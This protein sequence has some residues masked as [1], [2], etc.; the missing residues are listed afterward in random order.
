[1]LKRD[2]RIRVSRRNYDGSSDGAQRK[3]RLRVRSIFGGMCNMRVLFKDFGCA[4]N[5]PAIHTVTVITGLRRPVN[6]VFGFQLVGK[7]I[8]R[9][10]SGS[11]QNAV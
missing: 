9:R 3:R 10:E 2:C 4:R 8:G 6:Y 1:M 7:N 11:T 5:G